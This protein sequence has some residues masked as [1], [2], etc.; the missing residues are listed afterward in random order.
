[1]GVEHN[2]V[3]QLKNDNKAM[4]EFVKGEG[5]A[6]GVRHMELRMWYTRNEYAKGKVD[7]N[8]MNGAEIPSDHL[9]K[10]GTVEEHRKF[11]RSIQGLM[12]LPNDYFPDPAQLKEEVN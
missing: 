9:T 2:P 1:M 12:L 6:K 10:L 3:A 7:F 8:Y 5:M 4:I 11:A